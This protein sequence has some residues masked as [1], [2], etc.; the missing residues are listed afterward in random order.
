MRVYTLWWGWAVPFRVFL[1]GSPA[2]PSVE[3]PHILLYQTGFPMVSFATSTMVIILN[4]QHPQQ[5]YSP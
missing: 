3:F 5:I 4:I 2:F 1:G